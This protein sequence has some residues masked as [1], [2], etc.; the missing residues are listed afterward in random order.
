VKGFSE[1]AEWMWLIK[2]VSPKPSNFNDPFYELLLVGLVGFID[3]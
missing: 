2:S 1:P 3:D